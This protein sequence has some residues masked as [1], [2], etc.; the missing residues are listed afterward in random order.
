[1]KYH[2]LEPKFDNPS[3]KMPTHDLS[4]EE[5]LLIAEFLV[6]STRQIGAVDRVRFLVARL[7]PKPRLR[8][9][10]IFFEAGLGAG[11]F[12]AMALFVLIKKIR[13]IRAHSSI[14]DQVRM[15]LPR[16]TISS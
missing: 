6:S 13:S 9:L 10:G 4:E 14:R 8:H 15:W 5:A 11:L 16:L 1:M 2:L 3:S 7:V 12:G